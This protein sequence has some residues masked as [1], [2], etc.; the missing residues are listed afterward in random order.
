MG[1][2]NFASQFPRLLKRRLHNAETMSLQSSIEKPSGNVCNLIKLFV[3]Y[4]FTKRNGICIV[5]SE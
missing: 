5:F 3:C 1:L 4:L 2:H